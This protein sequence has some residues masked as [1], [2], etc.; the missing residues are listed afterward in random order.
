[1]YIKDYEQINYI[2]K[3]GEKMSYNSITILEAM[4]NIKDYRYV[5]P[6]IQREYVWKMEQIEQLFDSLLSDYPIGTFLFWEVLASNIEN[7]KFYLFQKDFNKEEIYYEDFTSSGKSNIIA[8][9]DG[10]QRLTSLYIGLYGSY[11]E[12]DINNDEE[13]KKYLYINLNYTYDKN[14]YNNNEYQFKFLSEEE[15]IKKNN[16]KD[17]W[18]K[19]SEL[20]NF[21]LTN[22]YKS[23]TN[24]HLKDNIYKLIK[25][26]DNKINNDKIINF[27]KISIQELD[28]I[29]NMFIRVNIGGTKLH[30]SDLILSK[31]TV[32]WKNND[33][34]K[35]INR[36]IA[37]IKKLGF[38]VSKDFIL[39]ASLMLTDNNIRF[40]IKNFTNDKVLQVEK[41]WKIIEK[42]LI[43]SFK[44]LKYFGYNKDYINSYNAI[45]PISY[46]LKNINAD[47][48]FIHNDNEDCLTVLKWFQISSIKSIFSDSSDS[49]LSKYRDIIKN[50]VSN[51]SK[52]FPINIIKNEFQN[53]KREDISFTKDYAS[54][55]IQNANYK[56]KKLLYPVL[57]SVLSITNIE[58]TI[59]HLYP[60]SFFSNENIIKYNLNKEDIDKFLNNISNLQFLAKNDNKAKSNQNFEDWIKTKDDN[61]KLNNLIPD[62][63]YSPSNFIKF[64]IERQK[65]MIDKLYSYLKIE[66]LHLSNYNKPKVII[67][68]ANQDGN[69]ENYNYIV[70]AKKVIVKKKK[71]IIHNKNNNNN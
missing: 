8:V 2:A 47:N 63:D 40:E 61:Y 29:L 52:K 71:I 20:S 34:K 68:K 70:P 43:L 30:Y 36:L 37:K 33:A 22:K 1:M 60:K 4:D 7:H 51:Y 13:V 42:Y 5:L 14:G 62:M 45:L 67:K 11:V 56:N 69:K 16:G 44:T 53:S 17:L 57:L 18:V 46:Y 6:D 15:T 3:L 58:R 54:K 48:D 31:I 23:L 39:K 24:N 10:Q 26:F 66:N 9:V 59:D 32:V 64:C 35:S 55:I 21:L 65:L 19:V 25:K 12:K 38:K 41:S 49:T 27:Y 28:K 50:N